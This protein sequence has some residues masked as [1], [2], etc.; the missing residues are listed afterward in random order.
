MFQMH[1]STPS[2]DG[3]SDKYGVHSHVRGILIYLIYDISLQQ[4]W[5]SHVEGLLWNYQESKKEVSLDC[6]NKYG[7]GERDIYTYDD[8]FQSGIYYLVNSY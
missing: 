6:T 1:E 4:E 3:G 5:A 7:K 2:E 8:V